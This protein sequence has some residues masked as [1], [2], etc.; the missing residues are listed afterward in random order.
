MDPHTAFPGASAALAPAEGRRALVDRWLQAY[1]RSLMRLPRPIDLRTLGSSAEGV[2]DALAVGLADADGAPGHGPMREAEKRFAF[3]GGNF[4]TDGGSAFDIVAL[5]L[6]LRDVLTLE[7]IAPPERAALAKLFDWLAALALEGY[8]TSRVDS[9]RQRNRDAL[10]RGTPVVMIT[11]EL[12][13]A[14]LVGEPDRMVLEG[15]FGRL[16]LSVVR[17][18]ARAV[19]IDATGLMRSADAALLDSLSSFG[20]HRKV[21]GA[22]QLIVV[23]VTGDAVGA[24]TDAIGGA[25]KLLVVERFED[26]VDAALAASGLKIGRR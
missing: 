12:P 1:E 3:L 9:I 13:A 18:G 22:V 11:P 16:L 4:G 6:A 26:A 5:V 15:A 21:A 10:D 24:W 17:V 14:L 20:R 2:L 8:V 23:G 19:I 7:A 25:D